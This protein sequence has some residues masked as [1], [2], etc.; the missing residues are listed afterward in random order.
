MGEL[1]VRQFLMYLVETKKAGPATRKMYVAGI[2]FLYE[3]T[4]RRPEVV[5]GMATRHKFEALRERP[6][7]EDDGVDAVINVL[8]YLRRKHPRIK[9]VAQELRYF[10]KNRK[11]MRY[12]EWRAKG[13]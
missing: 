7:M 3:V 12:A 6:L 8:T 9:R 2:K 13:S 4:L 11:R 5:A 1:E 10:R